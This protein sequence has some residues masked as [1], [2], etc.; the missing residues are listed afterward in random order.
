MA[1]IR[2]RRARTAAAAV[3]LLALVITGCAASETDRTTGSITIQPL[4]TSASGGGV[5]SEII[6]LADG[7]DGEFRLDF[8]EDEVA[9]LGDASRAASWNAAIV[10]TL[11][12]GAP[13]QARIRFETSGRIDGPSA[14]ALKTIGLIALQNG[15]DIDSAV[16][17]TGTINST[18]AI[19]P[20]GGIPEKVT[21]AADAGLEKVLIPLGQRNSLD[22]AGESVDVIRA[23][24]RLGVEVVEV[25]DVFEAYE[26]LTGEPLEQLRSN[27]EPRIDNRSYDK[28][29]AQVTAALGTFGELE[30]RYNAL[31]DLVRQAMAATGVPVQAYDSRDEAQRLREQSLIA[32][33]FTKAQNAVIVMRT[34][35]AAGELITPVYAQGWDGLASV[36]D[37][38]LDVGPAQSRTMGFLDQ[39]GT[40]S[41]KNLSDV[42][43]LVHA[44]ALAFDAYTLLDF[45]HAGVQ[46]VYDRWST[47]GYGGLDAL[48]F[49]LTQPLLYGELAKAQVDYAESVHELGRDNPGADLTEGVDLQSVGDFFRRAAD[50]NYT[51]FVSTGLVPQL[52]EQHG[53]SVDAVLDI[54]SK[55]DL[56][57]AAARHQAAVEPALA[58]YIGEDKP[59]AAYATMAYGIGNFVRNQMLIEKYYNNVHLDENLQIAG[60]T[61]EASLANATALS[62]ELLEYEIS[63]LRDLES[64]PVLSVAQYEAASVDATGEPL[65]R[66]GALSGYTQGFVTG[67]LLGYLGGFPA[68]EAD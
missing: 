68:D 66:F 36:F 10:S 34:V 63:R 65:D 33:A 25:G 13:V 59:N 46:T 56:S 52:A 53:M 51:A 43:G 26:H 42:E 67:R 55:Q 8:S 16:S 17:M 27:D 39:L 64:P 32:G 18:G 14:G 54:L 24:E 50:A 40:H 22:A 9:G 45:A 60:V 2:M 41:P 5:G 35:V 21:G 58:A 57:I 49:D 4:F 30:H 23:G 7:E 3:M 12:T 62:R 19:G 15:D 44:Y 37:R 28:F 1:T 6:T 31:P 48:F 20:V 38:S 11:L 61:N 47:G 29:D